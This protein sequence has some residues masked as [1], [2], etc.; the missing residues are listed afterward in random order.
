MKDNQFVS[1][2]EA[3]KLLAVHPQT[4]RRMLYDNRLVGFQL[5]TFGRWRISVQSIQE[6]V[7]KYRNNKVS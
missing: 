2:R 6:L 5:G 3:S 1:V 4:I 7:N